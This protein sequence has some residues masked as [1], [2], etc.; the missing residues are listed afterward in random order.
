LGLIPCRHRA[1]KTITGVTPAGAF[2]ASARPRPCMVAFP[3]A[4]AHEILREGRG[5]HFDPKVVDIFFEKR[6]EIEEV[7]RNFRNEVSLDAL[8]S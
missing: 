4:G 7:Q 3:Y 6:I 8:A 1:D 2:D 5:K